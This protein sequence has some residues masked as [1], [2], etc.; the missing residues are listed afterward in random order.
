MCGSGGGGGRMRGVQGRRNILFCRDFIQRWSESVSKC[1]SDAGYI[2]VR[3]VEGLPRTQE[4]SLTHTH[5][6]THFPPPPPTPT[7]SAESQLKSRAG[8]SQ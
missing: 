7:P 5:T 3:R 1:G 8:A 4:F 2:P 6:H